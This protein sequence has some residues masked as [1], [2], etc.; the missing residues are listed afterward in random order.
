VQ[1]PS[2]YSKPAADRLGQQLQPGQPKGGKGGFGRVFSPPTP[3]D[4]SNQGCGGGGPKS[5]TARFVQENTS[6]SAEK[7]TR[8]I[9]AHDGFEAKLTDKSTNHLTSRH[10]HNFGIDHPLPS[11]PNQKPGQYVQ[12]RTRINK[13][14]KAKLGD[15]VETILEDPTTQVFPEITIRGIQSRGYYTPKYNEYGT[16]I[17]IHT[18]GDFAGQIKKAQPVSAQQLEILFDQKKID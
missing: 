8:I 11:A 6:S 14:N 13:I 9:K 10:G 4:L 1:N 12:P 5:V 18:E 15:R 7:H 16:F 17:G 3:K 2:Q